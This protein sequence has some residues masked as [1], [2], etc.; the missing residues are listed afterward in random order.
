[1]SREVLQLRMI[2]L[3]AVNGVAVKVGV[4]LTGRGVLV[5]TLVMVPVGISVPVRLAV[6]VVEVWAAVVGVPVGAVAVIGGGRIMGVGLWMT[7][8]EEAKGEG[9]I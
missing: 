7:G 2:A 1:M 9:E 5:S 3:T 4:K 8:V 6:G